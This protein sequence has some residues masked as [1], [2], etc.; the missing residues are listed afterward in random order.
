[1]PAPAHSPRASFMGSRD[2]LVCS[3]FKGAPL[4]CG[5]RLCGLFRGSAV[6]SLWWGAWRFSLSCETAQ[7]ANIQTGGSLAEGRTPT[8]RRVLSLRATSRASWERP[9]M[10]CNKGLWFQ[11]GWYLARC[12]SVQC[13]ASGEIVR[14]LET[15][16]REENQV[17]GSLSC[18]LLRPLI[19]ILF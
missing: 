8:Q 15:C 2:L 11:K 12:P 3:C 5:A 19:K 4:E 9:G 18:N 16:C 13:R 1:M 14:R 10:Y 17:A 7:E 6:Q